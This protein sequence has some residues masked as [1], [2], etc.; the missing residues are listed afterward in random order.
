MDKKRVILDTDIGDD[1][2]D[3]YALAFLLSSPDVQLEGVCTVHGAV[4]QRA[5]LARKL[6]R[7]AGREDVPVIIG[8]T[9]GGDPSAMP[10]QAPWAS[11][12]EIST[13]GRDPVGFVGDRVA[14]SPGQIYLAAIGAL[15]NVGALLR[16]RPRTA[17]QLAG[18]FVMGG[19]IYRGYS[20]ADRPQA[21][22]NIRCDP[23]AARTVFAAGA[24]LT[25][26]P[27]D[28]TMSTRLSDEHMKR[29][30][31]SQAPLARALTALLP[32]WRKASGHNPIL[33]DPLTAAMVVNP[34][35]CATRNMRIEVAD[36]GMTQPV[37]GG[38]PNARV[39]LQ[40]DA[41]RFFEFYLSRLLGGAG[42]A[43]A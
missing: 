24:N 13:C 7:V 12:T 33:H 17:K 39:C 15:T 32:L 18:L 35:L 36:D 37:E 22:Y 42:K 1:I 2:D 20:V 38:K 5:R 14:A 40:V 25:L 16:D 8:L 28:V 6:L 34:T 43:T 3:A 26:V 9:G 29:I 21:E 31:E 23:A 27:L 4:E 30:G 10:N 11:D 19:S 41:E